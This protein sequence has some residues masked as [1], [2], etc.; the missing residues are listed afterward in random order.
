MEN[1]TNTIAQKNTLK[2]T[3]PTHYFRLLL[4]GF[5]AALFCIF[6]FLF[7]ANLLH[8]QKIGYPLLAL[9]LI[10]LFFYTNYRIT[11][12]N[13]GFR[14]RTLFRKETAYRFEDIVEIATASDRLEISLPHKVIEMAN[15]GEK[16]ALFVKLAQS[17]GVS[18]VDVLSQTDD[19]EAD[20]E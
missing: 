8:M 7:N 4:I 1:K 20:T 13:D 5:G 10:E 3:A 9:S 14:H 12:H 18:I 15:R 16:A 17:K 19:E 2:L 11:F 6:G